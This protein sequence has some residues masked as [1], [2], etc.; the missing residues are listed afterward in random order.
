MCSC[1]ILVMPRRLCPVPS[2][3]ALLS[4]PFPPSHLPKYF[5]GIFSRTEAKD[6]SRCAYSNFT[7]VGPAENRP[8]RDFLRFLKHCRR[9][10]LR[11]TGCFKVGGDPH[12]LPERCTDPRSATHE[13]THT[14]TDTHTH[15]PTHTHTTHTHTHTRACTH[16][17]SDKRSRALEVWG[18]HGGS[19]AR[20][21]SEKAK[22]AVLHPY[23]PMMPH[24]NDPLKFHRCPYTPSHIR[25]MS[26][27]A[28]EIFQAWA[29]GVE[30]VTPALKKVVILVFLLCILHKP[31]GI[32][33]GMLY[34]TNAF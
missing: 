8:R 34:R 1:A 28:G 5:R 27:H 23:M 24:Q 12:Q 17:Q 32:P 25:E 33:S 14:H 21:A 19:R 20:L 2:G 26:S 29:R 31:F 9:C 13:H 10:R 7:V 16:R 11:A 3:M 30:D 6:Y 4:D 18:A 22:R 15:T